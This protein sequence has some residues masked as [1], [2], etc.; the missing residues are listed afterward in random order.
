MT[1]K[2]IGTFSANC[3]V[4]LDARTSFPRVIIRR[5]I[6]SLPFEKHDRMTVV[7]APLQMEVRALARRRLRRVRVNNGLRGFH[8]IVG[9]QQQV[10]VGR[11]NFTFAHQPRL[12]PPQQPRPI[13]PAK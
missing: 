3:L 10:E 12:Y 4:R 1:D 7:A 9:Q 5:S 13:V 6:W 2:A 8:R 11:G